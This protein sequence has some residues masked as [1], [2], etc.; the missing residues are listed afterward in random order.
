MRRAAPTG[1]PES[2][3][4]EAAASLQT[5]VMNERRMLEWLLV[6]LIVALVINFIAMFWILWRH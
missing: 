3:C 6:L 1:G 2:L 5:S 4:V